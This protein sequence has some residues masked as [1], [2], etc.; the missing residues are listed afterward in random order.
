MEDEV[1][2]KQVYYP[3]SNRIGKFL[4]RYETLENGAE[5]P[6][7]QALFGLCVPLEVV[8]H[9]CG[10]GKEFC[11][12]S[13]MFQPLAEGE[14]IPQYRI[15][16]EIARPFTPEENAKATTSGRFKFYAVRRIIVRVPPA[17]L[18]LS[19]KLPQNLH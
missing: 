4:I 1:V 9:E 16:C 12:A 6:W 13:E 19:G 8:D 3:A 10:R 18:S 5:R 7:L 14:E 15:E 17:T 11:C 2:N